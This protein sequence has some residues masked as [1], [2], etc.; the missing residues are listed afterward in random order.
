MNSREDFYF[1]DRFHGSALH[2]DWSIA[3]CEAYTNLADESICLAGNYVRKEV[4][5]I[6]RSQV[7]LEILYLFTQTFL[8]TAGDVLTCTSK[9]F[10]GNICHFFTNIFFLWGRL[11]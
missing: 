11:Y 1:V 6:H 2:D 7:V 8:A 3:D 10:C 9:L 5:I 4:L